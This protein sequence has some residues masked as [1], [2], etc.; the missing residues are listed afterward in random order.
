MVLDHRGG[1]LET[2]RLWMGAALHPVYVVVQAPY[3]LWNW[4]NGSFTDRAQLRRHNEQLTEE[5]RQA[6]IR[7]LQFD[8]L[9]EENRRLRA[10]R[11][12]SAGLAERTQLA[13]IMH[14]DVDP[15]RHRVRIDKGA[16]DGVFRSQP[17]V[18]AF[19]IV[20]QVAAV[21]QYS[22]TIIL[23]SDNQHA[24]PV[25]VNRNGIRS[26]AV[27]TGDVS[28]LILPYLTV[29]SD[30]RVGDLL[31]SSG[32]DGIFPA[33]YPV[34][35]ISQIDRI[36][37]ATFA[38]VEARPLAQLDRDR[39]VLLLW[40]EEPASAGEIAESRNPDA[41]SPAGPAHDGVAAAEHRR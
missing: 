39:E 6:R 22:A 37:S 38:I 31:V 28:K 5:L 34:A 41:A 27:G 11:Q 25:Q 8:A 14:V 33:G 23:I 35:V 30:V 36:P 4:L 9:N 26:I 2:A 19:G 3:D 18:D 40:G 32:L 15:F 29:Q 13:S 1:Y 7:L 16:G 20:G 12:A 10:I 24:I 17:V 21:D